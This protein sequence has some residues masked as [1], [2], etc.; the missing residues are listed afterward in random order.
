M[1]RRVKNYP[2]L[3]IKFSSVIKK[4]SSEKFVKL[5]K[6]LLRTTFV[7]NKDLYMQHRT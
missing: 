6:N 3:K 2:D 1:K 4:R 5:R 7:E